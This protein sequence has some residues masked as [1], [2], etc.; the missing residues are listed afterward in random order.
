[1]NKIAHRWNTEMWKIVDILMLF[2]VYFVYHLVQPPSIWCYVIRLT[3]LSIRLNFLP[4]PPAIHTSHIH[5]L[6]RNS[7]LIIYFSIFFS[8]IVICT[9]RNFRKALCSETVSFWWKKCLLWK[10]IYILYMHVIMRSL[11]CFSSSSSSTKTMCPKV[12]RTFRKVFFFF[13]PA[14]FEFISSFAFFHIY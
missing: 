9:E 5:E 3:F 8:S 13:R 2:N 7:R 1:M 10:Q 6:H 14:L 12:D 11:R 4:A